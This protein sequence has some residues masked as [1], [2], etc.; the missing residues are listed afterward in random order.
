MGNR[1]AAIPLAKP[2]AQRIDAKA[3]TRMALKRHPEISA[4]LRN[5]LPVAGQPVILTGPAA[6]L[7]HPDA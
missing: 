7:P 4:R 5:D 6:P 3:A 1:Q 2:R